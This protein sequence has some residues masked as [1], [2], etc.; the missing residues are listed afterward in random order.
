MNQKASSVGSLAAG[1][2]SKG[3]PGRVTR[4]FQRSAYVKSGEDFI[5]LLWGGLRSP[6]TINIEG[7]T[8]TGGIRAGERCRLSANGVALDSGRIDVEGAE[9][10]RSALIDGAE[11]TL[12]ARAALRRGVAMLR[13][14][15]DVS[16]SGPTLNKDVALRT[17]AKTTL[18]PLA[19]GKSSGMYSPSSYL[20][21]VGR[22]GGFTPAGDD[23]LGGLLATF[24]FV[25]R[26][27][28]SREIRIPRALLRGRTVPE[29]ANVLFHS[30]RGHVD[31]GMGR[32]VLRSLDGSPGFSDELVE[33]AH[34]GHT[35][36]ID[37]SLGVVLCE[38]ALAQQERGERVLK[39]CL[40]VLWRP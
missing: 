9:I 4:V 21:L 19:S 16:P 5:L 26:C 22:G 3:K 23:F 2:L 15:Y 24:N 27:R 12:P 37:M 6:M 8:A 18:I 31:E 34:R 13:S 20:P 14:L 10:F 1:L 40:D 33:V 35:S 39:D 7:S 29:S 28:K 30:A 38:A 25:A 17:F 11:V 36:G 32:L